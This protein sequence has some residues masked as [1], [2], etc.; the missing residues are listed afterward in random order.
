MA[1]RT[2]ARTATAASAG[3]WRRHTPDRSSG[4]GPRRHSG[5]LPAPLVVLPFPVALPSPRP[6][7]LVLLLLLVLLPFAGRRA[8]D[9]RR[10]PAAATSGSSGNASARLPDRAAASTLVPK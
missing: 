1:V 8:L 4:P 2:G 10:P 5:R 3:R 7:P 9:R 6:L